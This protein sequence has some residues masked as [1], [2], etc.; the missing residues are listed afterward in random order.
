MRFGGLAV[1]A[2]HQGTTIDFDTVTRTIQELELREESELAAQAE[3]VV[4]STDMDELAKTANLLVESLKDT[5]NPKFRDSSFMSLMRQL[6][7]REVVVEG[8]DLKEVTRGTWASEFGPSTQKN[9]GKAREEPAPTLRRKSVHFEPDA[10]VIESQGIRIASPELESDLDRVLRQ[11][12]EEYRMMN[13]EMSKVLD[14]SKTKEYSLITD[15]TSQIPEWGY[16]QDD[17]EKFEASATGI[18]PA[19]IYAFQHQNPYMTD[20]FSTTRHHSFHESSRFEVSI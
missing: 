6:R 17:W 1:N 14:R 9:K 11:E 13:A 12:N 10:S 4:S 20:D 2:Q 15:M 19:S 8:N 3:Q 16:L 5:E 18:H 7:D